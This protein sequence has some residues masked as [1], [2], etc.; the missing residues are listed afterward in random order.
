MVRATFD[1]PKSAVAWIEGQLADLAP[2]MLSPQDRR[3]ERVAAVAA[4]AEETLAWGGDLSLG[5]YTHG[6]FVKLDMIGCSPNLTA[7][8]LPCPLNR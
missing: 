2:S 3:P 6:G 5:W 4:Y 7:N 8:A 1:E